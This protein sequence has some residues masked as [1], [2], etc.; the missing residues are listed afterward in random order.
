MSNI[1][2]VQREKL[3][4]VL[5]LLVAPLLG[6]IA[7]LSVTLVL[8]TTGWSH[9]VGWA[10]GVFLFVSTL[11]QHVIRGRARTAPGR[12]LLFAAGLG[13]LGFVLMDVIN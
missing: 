13:A 12:T 7:S 8:R 1:L 3:P 5:T 6:L 10:L 2:L 11:T 4:P 9:R